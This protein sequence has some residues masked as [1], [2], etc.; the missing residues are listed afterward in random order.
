M[1]CPSAMEISRNSKGSSTCPSHF[2]L[3]RRKCR[4]NT[5]GY[6][7]NRVSRFTVLGR[8][9]KLIEDGTIPAGLLVPGD[10]VERLP[11]A[12][13]CRALSALFRGAVAGCRRRSRAALG[14]AAA[15]VQ[16]S[17][18]TLGADAAAP[19][20]VRIDGYDSQ[21]AGRSGAGRLSDR[22]AGRN[23]APVRTV[24]PGLLRALGGHLDRQKGP[25]LLA[26][27]HASVW[28]PGDRIPDRLG[29]RCGQTGARRKRPLARD[30]GTSRRIAQGHNPRRPSG[31]GSAGLV[32]LGP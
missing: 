29:T 18:P 1:L 12:L 32:R 3:R 15:G 21:H 17:G 10:S 8:S 14:L 6:L 25:A 7:Q 16:I 24:L 26:G 19:L 4:A 22:A 20:A 11:S 28:P 9:A 5:Y 23:H 13:S 30:P 2:S 31:A 27:R